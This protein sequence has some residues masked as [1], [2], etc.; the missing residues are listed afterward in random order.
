M[1]VSSEGTVTRWISLLK[2]GDAQA[3]QELWQAYSRRLVALARTR[4]RSTRR[5]AADEEDVRR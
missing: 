3:A 1:P 4:L 5:G 2:D